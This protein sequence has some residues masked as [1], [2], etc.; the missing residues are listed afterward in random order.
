MKDFFRK[1]ER[2]VWG[3]LIVKLARLPWRPEFWKTVDNPSAPGGKIDMYLIINDDS[4]EG[5]VSV[6]TP[7]GRPDIAVYIADC[8]ANP[9]MARPD[10]GKSL[11]DLAALFNR[12]IKQHFA[13]DGMVDAQEVTNAAM[14]VIE[15][16][17]TDVPARARI[18]LVNTI[19][20][21][22]SRLRGEAP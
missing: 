5:I 7:A 9:W 13:K 22:F 6:G 3:D 4:G 15:A 1:K 14:T 20:A 11:S 8:C 18:E 16:Y 17:L 12:A 21:H 10:D 2:P 19:S